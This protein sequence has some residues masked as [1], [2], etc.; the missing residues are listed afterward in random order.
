MQSLYLRQILTNLN[1]VFYLPMHAVQKESSTTLKIRVVLDA[2]AKSSSNV[3]L[4]DI[5]LV[6]PMIHSSLIDVLQTT[7][8]RPDR[9]REQN[10]LGR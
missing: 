4:N 8:Y 6:S 9:Q 10:V 7:L 5:L 3:S 1:T 2:S